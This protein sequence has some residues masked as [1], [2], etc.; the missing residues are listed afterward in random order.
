M[1][2]E[3][4]EYLKYS[5][6]GFYVT[7]VLVNKLEC[8]VREWSHVLRSSGFFLRVSPTHQGN[9]IKTATHASELLSDRTLAKLKA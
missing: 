2:R 1:E 4:L 5:V 7:H 8:H 3:A 9:D 6:C